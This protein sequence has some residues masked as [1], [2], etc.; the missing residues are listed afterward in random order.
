M[1]AVSSSGGRG[2]SREASTGPLAACSAM[3]CS[4]VCIAGQGRPH[5][6]A[7]RLGQQGPS[8]LGPLRRVGL[9]NHGGWIQPD[10][11]KDLATTPV[12]CFEHYGFPGTGRQTTARRGVRQPGPGQLI[13]LVPNQFGAEGPSVRKSTLRNRIFHG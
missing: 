12:I 8:P 13:G 5:Q 7:E 10:R 1:T 6:E 4:A 11:T 2:G 9:Q 3:A